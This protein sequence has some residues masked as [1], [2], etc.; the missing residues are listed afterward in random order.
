MYFFSEED[1]A[2]SSG[3][4]LPAAGQA[5]C[6]P[7]GVSLGLSQGEAEADMP[8]RGQ[9]WLVGGLEGAACVSRVVVMPCA[10]VEGVAHGHLH[11]ELF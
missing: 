7:S 8:P 6:L 10:R 3:L 2:R 4:P 1:L 9:L 5:R 11:K